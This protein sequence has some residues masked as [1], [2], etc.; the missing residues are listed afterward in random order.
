[1]C[2][3]ARSRCSSAVLGFPFGGTLWWRAMLGLLRGL[4]EGL[5]ALVQPQPRAEILLLALAGQ[6]DGSPLR[7]GCLLESA[8]GGVGGRERVEAGGILTGSAGAQGK[9]QRPL[10]LA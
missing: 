3:R 7:L 6:F 5:A 1:M 2:Q 4:D 8:T 10:R 9:L